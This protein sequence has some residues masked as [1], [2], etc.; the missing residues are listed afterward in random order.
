MIH[1]KH[2][3]ELKTLHGIVMKAKESHEY[4]MKLKKGKGTI[5]SLKR[6]ERYIN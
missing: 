2:K 3:D 4:V 6:Y 1:I 5:K